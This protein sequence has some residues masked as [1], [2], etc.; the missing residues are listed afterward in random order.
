MLETVFHILPFR[1]LQYIFPKVFTVPVLSYTN[2]GTINKEKLCFSDIQVK[3]GYITGAIKFV[4]YFQIAASTFNDRMTLSCNLYGTPQD[5]K[6][7][8]DFLDLIHQELILPD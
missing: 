7:I 3:D 8:S 2:L 1:L 4:P 6:R 5:W